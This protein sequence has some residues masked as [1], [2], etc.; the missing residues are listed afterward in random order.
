MSPASKRTIIAVPPPTDLRSTRFA[1][2]TFFQYLGMLAIV[3]VI[4]GYPV[5]RRQRQKFAWQKAADNLGLDCPN[6][7][8]FEMPSIEGHLRGRRVRAEVDRKFKFFKLKNDPRV[9]KYDNTFEA[10]LETDCFRQ[11]SMAEQK[12][13]GKLGSLLGGED[14]ET[15]FDDIDSRFRVTG[16][17]GAEALDCLEDDRVRRM[18][19]W[20]ANNYRIVAIEDGRLRLELREALTSAND[21]TRRIERAV[22]G[23]E[24][25][26]EAAGVER[27]P[28]DWS[29]GDWDAD[30]EPDD[31]VL[32]PDVAE[33][34]TA[35][36]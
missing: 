31:D 6:Q 2:E 22:A 25:L 5:Y 4:F 23:A 8:L 34:T 15:G 17:L 33:A 13:A 11:F 7:S 3:V 16:T 24:T 36:D 30:D 9:A 20:M 27:N 18:L 28:D 1:I 10:R 14:I 19:V 21:I 35:H 26:D 32:F 29:E 12:I